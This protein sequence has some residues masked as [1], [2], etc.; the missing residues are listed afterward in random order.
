M[1][2]SV[3]ATGL[4]MGESPRWH[5]GRLWVCDW[6]A[7]EIVAV[8]LDGHKQTVAG[9]PFGLPFC[10]DWLPDG[11]LLIVSGQEGRVYRREADGALQVYADLSRLSDRGWNEIVV[12]G[13]GNTYVNGSGAI[14]LILLDGTAQLVGDGGVFPNGMAVAADGSTLILAESLDKKLTVFD[15]APDGELSGRRVWA[16]LKDGCPDGICMDADGAVWYADVP[17]K[18]CVRVAEGGAVLD[19]VA[20]DRGCF[21]CMLG[22]PERKTLFVVA[23]EWHGMARIAETAQLKT[24]QVLAV[25]VAVGGAGW[26]ARERN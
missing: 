25:D 18:C 21:A 2:L 20:V 26:P 1:D 19:R 11:R 23:N 24:G 16:D 8:G 15:I 22:G 7:R 9:V 3:M 13:R 10:I 17:N 14:A 4:S 5:D 6:G 12:D